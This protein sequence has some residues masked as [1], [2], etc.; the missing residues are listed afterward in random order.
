MQKKTMTRWT[1]ILST[2][3]LFFLTVID[4]C[5][6]QSYSPIIY[7]NQQSQYFGAYNLITLQQSLYSFEDK[8]IRDTIFKENNFFKKTLGFGYR[9]SKLILLDGQVDGFIA[10]SQHEAFGHGAR[11]RELGYTS[12]SFNLNLYPP[13]GNGGGFAQRGILQSDYTNPTYQEN[14]AVNIGGVDAEML[15]ANNLANQILLNDTLHYRQGILYLVSQNN[16]L[17]YL[18]HTRY[19]KP[20]NIK[21]GNDMVNYIN[22]VN[23]FYPHPANKN[24]D[25]EKLSAQS[26][27]SFANPVQLYSAFTILYTYGIKGQ[28]QLKKI[29][30]IKFGSVRYLPAFNYSL[31]PFGSQYHFINYI[32]YKSILFTGDFNLGDNTFNKFYG[33]SINGFNLVDKKGIGLNLH[34]D[35]WS[36]PDLELEKYLAPSPVNKIGEAFKIDLML[37]P[38]NRKNKLGLFMQLGYKTKGYITGE[39][40]AESF[41]LRYGISLHL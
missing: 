14:I 31:T 20:A 36:Q 35:I 11:Y 19:T 32:R 41:I 10:L 29:P 17:L 5:A 12:N 37:R 9:M 33:V 23:Y 8:Y 25:L 24:Y 30:M 15:L 38:F 40:L 4:N 28:K 26:L 13:F 18:W 34:F 6:A 2:V 1:I 27:L 21:A 39:P 16:L 22:N 7:D 3:T